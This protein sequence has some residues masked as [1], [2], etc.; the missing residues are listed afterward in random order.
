MKGDA[1]VNLNMCLALI[2]A[3]TSI[4]AGAIA[5]TCSPPQGFVNQP[6][7]A[8]VAP[9]R[10]AAHT[11]EI[12]VNRPLAIVVSTAERTNIKD[13]IHKAGDLPSVTGEYP[14][15]SIP[16]GTHGARR[17]VCLSDGSTLEEQVLELEAS[18][19]FHRF[20]YMVW[21]YTTKQA[22]PIEYGIGEFRHTEIDPS[23]THIVWTYSFKLK[24]NEFP[25]YL[26]A[27]GRTLFHWVFLDR[28]Y[29]AMM[30]A[31]LEAGKVDAE[32]RPVEEGN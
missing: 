2:V 19:N 20:R 7:P 30:R 9:E 12:T 4:S 31:T 17:L 26:G 3:A 8:L 5:Q 11:E 27:L 16:F 15:N 25:G 21:N 6:P 13:A 14:L 10:L 18:K 23:H 22:R 29:A 32:K 1:M 28:D 24:S